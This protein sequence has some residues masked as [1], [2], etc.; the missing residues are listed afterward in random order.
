MHNVARLA[1]ES[2]A[3]LCLFDLIDEA[4]ERLYVTAAAHRQP[5]KERLL[6]GITS[7]LYNREFGVHPVVR[8]TE[9]GE[10]FFIEQIDQAN[11]R[12]HA[13]SQE[14]E[15]FMRKL[16]Y[17]SKIVV[18]VV[19]QGRVFG[20]L[21]FVR[22]GEGRSFDAG[23]LDFARELGRRAGLAV[24]NAKQ[25]HREQHVAETLQRAFLTDDFPQRSN[26]RFSAL[27][28]PGSKDSELGGDWYDAFETIDGHIVIAIG[29]VTGKGLEAARLMVQM[30]QSVRVAAV[31]SSR[32]AEI[33]SD[34]NEV[35]L[36]DRS[37]RLVSTFVG[38]LAPNSDVLEYA[39]AGHVPPLMRGA[40]GAIKRLEA[41]SAPLGVDRHVTF[42]AHRVRV[43]PDAML[44]LYT[45]GII[46]IDRDV[47]RG[48]RILRRVLASPAA[49]HATNPARYIERAI[50]GAIARDDI[51]I[52]VLRFGGDELQWRLEVSDPRAAYA[53]RREFVKAVTDV[54]DATVSDFAACEL[55]FAELIGNAVRHAPGPLSIALAIEG[56]GVTL[57]LIDEGPGF[58]FDPSL[59][60]DMWAEGG[61]GLFLVSRMARDV[62]VTRLPGC[63]SHIE[64]GLPVVP[65]N[66][67]KMA[68]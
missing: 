67:R 16:D 43:A 68:S 26:L 65:R 64:I 40:S 39:S 46:E 34:C 20:A 63:G 5:E 47:L 49:T 29:D 6:Q 45:D 62:T 31:R 38:V 36:Q 57:H 60:T 13:A 56:D 58:K 24:A 61:R 33:L 10:P 42:D 41:P 1:V 55:I 28:R 4:S 21:T 53:V 30:R 17:R 11:L 32:P 48:E 66:G 37:G 2:F 8:V 22:T 14:H 18:P 12:H 44:V 59:P 27:Y 54:A 35:L 25:Y 9:T 50:A 23:D 52:M 19:A 3:D 15:R 51:A 7:L